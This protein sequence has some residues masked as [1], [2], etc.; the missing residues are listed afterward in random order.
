MSAYS[1]IVAEILTPDELARLFSLLGIL[2]AAETNAR[3]LNMILQGLKSDADDADRK[4]N[5]TS[6]VRYAE[7]VVSEYRGAIEQVSAAIKQR[8]AQP[9]EPAAT[10]H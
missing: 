10:L 4:L 7:Q 5:L 8:H 6:A 1:P 3:I 9:Q 2:T